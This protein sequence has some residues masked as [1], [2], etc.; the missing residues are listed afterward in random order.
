M[1][2]KYLSLLRVGAYHT[3]VGH[4]HHSLV[5]VFSSWLLGPS[6]STML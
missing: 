5:S 3:F 4:V 1:L 6:D 2:V